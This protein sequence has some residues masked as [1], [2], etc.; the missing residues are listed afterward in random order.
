MGSEELPDDLVGGEVAAGFPDQ[1]LREI[2]FAAG[3]SVA[4]AHHAVESDCRVLLAAGINFTSRFEPIGRFGRK[5]VLR[6]SCGA[7]IEPRPGFCAVFSLANHS[8]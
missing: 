3:P 1:K 5:G 4:A 7:A 8:S 2:L 6:C